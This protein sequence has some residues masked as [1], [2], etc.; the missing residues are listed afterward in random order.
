MPILI[1][2]GLIMLVIV[3]HFMLTHQ[4]PFFDLGIDLNMD[5]GHKKNTPFLAGLFSLKSV[6]SKDESGNLR[7]SKVFMR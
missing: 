6:E 5:V 7:D 4:I 2:F 1:L 3:Q